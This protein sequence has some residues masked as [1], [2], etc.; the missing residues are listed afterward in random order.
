[1]SVGVRKIG[2]AI[3]NT[4]VNEFNIVRDSRR[5]GQIAKGL[6]PDKTMAATQMM[7]RKLLKE[8]GPEP[9]AGLLLG[10]YTN[11]IPG[12]GIIGYAFGRGFAE[13]RK[14]LA[15]LIKNLHK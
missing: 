12:M 6:Y 3:I 2:N 9:V 5:A 10:T 7:V 14:A 11:P 15:K 1:M 8:V 13:G 4:A